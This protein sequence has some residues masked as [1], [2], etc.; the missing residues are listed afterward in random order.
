MK[1]FFYCVYQ[2]L[3]AY[4][5]GILITIIVAIVIM[6]GSLF[7]AHFLDYRSGRVW[8]RMLCW[9]FL[10]PV[11]VE[12]CAHLQKGQSYVFVSNHQSAFDIFMIYGYLN[13][14]FKWMMKASIRK[15]PFVGKACESARHIF[16]E[17]GAPHIIKAGYEQAQRTLRSGTSLVVFPEG[18]RSIT[19][20]IGTFKRG[21]FQLA[22]EINLPLVPLTINGAFDA[23]PPTRP[24]GFVRHQRLTLTIHPPILPPHNHKEVMLECFNTIQHALVSKYQK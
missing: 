5:I 4:P 17:R 11:K 7:N 12:G 2:L 13:R 23:L 8:G 9:L 3:I 16:I 19:G 22:E 20:K 10:M 6:F 15:I 1:H 21:A 24:F 14:N 18:H